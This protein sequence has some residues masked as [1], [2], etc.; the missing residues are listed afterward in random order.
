MLKLKRRLIAPFRHRQG[1][2]VMA[3]GNY[4]RGV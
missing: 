3:A 1:C 4:Q 2:P